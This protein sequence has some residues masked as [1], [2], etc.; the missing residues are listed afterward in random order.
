[1]RL[2][3]RIASLIPAPLASRRLPIEASLVS[4]FSLAWVVEARDPYTGGHL[5]RVSEYARL[6]ADRLGLAQAEA[7]RVAL[8]GF[9]HDLG[10]IGIP[11]SVLLKA[12]QLSDEQYAVIRTHPEVGRRLVARHPLGAIVMDAVHLHHERPDGKGYP[13]G[14]S[15]PG[16]PLTASIV[17]VCDA[18]DAMTSAR[19]YRRPMPIE[20]A[21]EIVREQRGTQFDSRCAD[22]LVDLGRS[23]A[24]LHIAGHS[25]DG[26]PLRECHACGPTVVLTKAHRIGEPVFC[27]ACG[28]GYETRAGSDALIAT[29]KTAN[30]SDRIPAPDMDLIDRLIA[31]LDVSS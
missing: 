7:G 31:K 13:L 4:L 5:W 26:I 14:L 22:A 19:P 10:K 8:G 18:F 1:M 15:E 11:D 21:L 17:G 29:G 24:L 25:E 23:M 3:D 20:R 9:L 2:F 12:G 6:V 28:T 30:A 27:P 16:I